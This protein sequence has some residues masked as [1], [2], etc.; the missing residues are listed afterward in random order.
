MITKNKTKAKRSRAENQQIIKEWIEDIYF[1]Y[2][3]L[4]IN[5][6][7]AE[8]KVFDELIETYPDNP[9]IR[10]YF[11]N[12]KNAFQSLEVKD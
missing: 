1:R 3:K 10:D 4:P 11:E 2:I 8:L 12:L 6:R 7:Q 5:Q 9:R